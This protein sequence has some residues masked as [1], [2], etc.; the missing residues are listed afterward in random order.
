[1][2]TVTDQKPQKY[3]TSPEC[4]RLWGYVNVICYPWI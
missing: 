1:M 3:I 4:N 2:L